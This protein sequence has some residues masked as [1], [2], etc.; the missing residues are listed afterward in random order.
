MFL[1]KYVSDCYYEMILNN[2]NYEF[3]ERLDES[4]FL[5]IYNIFHKYGFYF[6]DDI[7]LNYLDIFT[8]NALKVEYG[9]YKLRL[10][11]GNNYIY[12][13]GNDMRYLNK[14]LDIE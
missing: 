8:M 5:K 1:S 13:I 14:I 3:L 4:N 9:I 11:L 6:I 7:I 12:I 2:Y 10:T